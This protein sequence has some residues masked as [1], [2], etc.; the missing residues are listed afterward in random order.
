M[1]PWCPLYFLFFFF[2][3]PLLFFVN[4]LQP[5]KNSQPRNDQALTCNFLV[6]LLR[7]RSFNQ[8]RN[9]F[10]LFF[11]FFFFYFCP[12][13]LRKDSYKVKRKNGMVFGTGIFGHLSKDDPPN[14][15]TRFVWRGFNRGQVERVV[16][17]L[18]NRFNYS[19][20]RTPRDQWAS[21]DEFR[22]YRVPR[23]LRSVETIS[24]SNIKQSWNTPRRNENLHR[25]TFF[26]VVLE[27]TNEQTRRG[28]QE[29]YGVISRENANSPR[30]VGFRWRTSL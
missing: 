22:G 24:S 8:N 2:P 7:W 6:T 4:M 15:R 13:I 29:R 9:C 12:V 19:T 27:Q 20:Q 3:S 10:S 14:R 17:H 11:S 26:L 21:D 1:T 28:V 25:D 16:F 5:Q 18:Y 30:E 23:G